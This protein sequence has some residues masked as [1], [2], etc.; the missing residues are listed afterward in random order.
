MIQI[1]KWRKDGSPKTCC[2]LGVLHNDSK[3]GCPILN[4]KPSLFDSCYIC[5][6]LKMCFS[7]GKQRGGLQKANGINFSWAKCKVLN[8]G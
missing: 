2:M 1:S 3:F 5:F 6:C 4:L 8:H 7:N